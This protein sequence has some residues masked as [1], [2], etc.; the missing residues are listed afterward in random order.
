MAWEVEIFRWE[1]SIWAH[2]WELGGCDLGAQSTWAEGCR[3]E[4]GVKTGLREE[5][6]RLEDGSSDGGW[7]LC[8]RWVG[9]EERRGL[10]AWGST[11]ACRIW[12]HGGCSGVVWLSCYDG[13]EMERKLWR[14]G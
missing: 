12:V 6:Y 4:L 7:A 9:F 5:W 2:S 13:G 8:W 14:T 3:R 11:M 10:W 1:C